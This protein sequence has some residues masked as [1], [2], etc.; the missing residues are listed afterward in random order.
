MSAMPSASVPASSPARLGDPTSR[1][2]RRSRASAPYMCESGPRLHDPCSGSGWT[3]AI[4][5]RIVGRPL[6]V[7][8]RKLPMRCRSK[9]AD[10]TLSRRSIAARARRS[11]APALAAPAI[12]AARAARRRHRAT[13]TP[14]RDATTP[15]AAATAPERL[16]RRLPGVPGRQRVEPA[17]SRRCPS[18][19]NSAHY[20]AAHQRA[21][22]QARSCTPTS[23]ATARTASRSSSCPATQPT[24]ADRLH[25]L[26]R[27]ERP[28]P[29]PDPADAPVEGGEPATATCSSSTA[30]H[31]KL[32]ELFGARPGA[33]T[34]GTP[35]SGAIWDLRS[36]ALRPDGL[37]VGRR[38][39]AADLPGPRALRRG[40]ER[41]HRPRA[42]LHRVAARR[43][44]YIHPGDALRVVEHRPDAAADGAA[45][46]AEGELRRSSGFHGQARRDPRGAEEVRDDRRRQRLATGS[47]PA[48]PTP[49]GT[50]TT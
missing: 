26:R 41:P 32:Y 48:R 2:A 4:T 45:A 27:R 39:R 14:A 29:V 22:R 35:T 30:T 46:A 9:R 11:L 13:A 12:A 24:R 21:R 8:A 1:R 20:I 6:Q 17:T 18:T 36:N 16:A 50:T 47:S 25:R 7:R 19:P 23:A 49:A 40:R 3:P 42:A 28:G 33:A 44:G 10:R 38:R 37:D 15:V 43:R 5:A 31:C 34:T